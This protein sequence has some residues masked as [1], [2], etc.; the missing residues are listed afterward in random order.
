[1]LG[2]SGNDVQIEKCFSRDVVLKGRLCAG[3]IVG[4][5]EDTY[6]LTVRNCVGW[7]TS[8]SIAPWDETFYGIGY[9][10]GAWKGGWLDFSGCWSNESDDV[11]LM[12]NGA[13]MEVL[14]TERPDK[15]VG[16]G[17]ESGNRYCGQSAASFEEACQSAGISSAE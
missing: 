14:E 12:R 8:Y 7:C 15:T 5:A 3:G 13:A 9:I 4:S 1:M 10:I 16:D 2:K 6:G 17:T 11:Q